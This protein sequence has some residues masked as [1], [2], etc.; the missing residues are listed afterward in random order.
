MF[1]TLTSALLDLLS[2]QH[3]GFMMVGVVMGLIVG[4]LPGI[5]GLVGLSML[6]P[7]V[8]GMDQTSALAML[9]GVL[10]V[11]PTADTFASVLMGIPGGTSSQAT[12]LDGFPLSKQG[13]AARALSAAFS[14]SMIGGV[15]G[16]IVL[17]IFVI[18]ARP[19][20]LSFGTPELFMLT[21]FG[22]SMV[23]VLSG[24]NMAKGV[25]AAALGLGF[26]MIGAAPATGEYRM[27]FNWLYLTDGVPLVIVALGLFAV[28]EIVDLLRGQSSIAHKARSLGSGWL[29]GIKDS[30]TYR[31]L[32]LR[33]SGMGTIVGAIPGLGGAVVD[34]M[35][36]GHVMQTSKDRSQFGKGDIR[37]VIAPESANNACMG[38]ALMPTLLFGIPGSGAMAVFLSAMVL[39]GIQ[40][41]PA[42]ADPARN[43]DLTYTVV[44]SLAIA[45]IIGTALCVA[46]SP[47]I[48]RLTTIRYTLIAPFMIMV[49]SFAAFQATR[50][51]YD[52]IALLVFGVLG[53]FLRRFGWSR[54]AFLIG[55][56]LATEA[57]RYLYQAVQF[58]GWGFVTRPLV[59]A[60]VLVTVLSVWLGV[61]KRPN[62]SASVINTEGVA[63]VNPTGKV[64]PQVVFGAAVLAAFAFAFWESRSLSMLGGIFPTGIGI[65]GFL[66]TA[67]VLVPL[68]RGKKDS[69]ANFDSE[70]TVRENDVRGGAWGMIGWLAGFVAAIGLVGFSVALVVFFISFLRVIAKTGW[71]QTLVLT[72]CAAA[73]VLVLAWALNLVMPSGLLQAYVDLPWPLR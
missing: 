35:A 66:A 53:V 47:W 54:P 22:L 31:W 36:Y 62:G 27:E 5:G 67:C 37:G 9:I 13:Q 16:A 71:V 58:S 55:F 51:L 11:S 56:A 29:Q 61:R 70:F 30:W 7:F 65:V 18:I 41:G 45:S 12:V 10:A 52:M 73:F 21:I 2:L 63:E 4:V 8:Y 28:P 26:G 42:M 50:S 15:F 49:I 57:E 6:L 32:V 64:W 43:L 46:I 3:F 14:A 38:G 68:I 20:V 33:C 39:L 72:A 44:W 1:E 19:I 24:T 48:S 25:A 60:I 34:W 40:P 59:I 69:S 17:T 23:G